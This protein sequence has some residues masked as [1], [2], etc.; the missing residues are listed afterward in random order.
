MRGFV[1]QLKTI[2]NRL[3]IK[4]NVTDKE[5][6]VILLKSIRKRRESNPN[7]RFSLALAGIS[8]AITIFEDSDLQNC[9]FFYYSPYSV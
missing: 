4:K 1:Y 7:G 9:L 3:K 2:D 6:I 8:G 5:L